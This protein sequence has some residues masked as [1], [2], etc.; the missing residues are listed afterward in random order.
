MLQCISI[1]FEEIIHGYIFI[2]TKYFI[3]AEGATGDKKADSSRMDTFLSV[4]ITSPSLISKLAAIQSEINQ[5][6][7][8][9]SRTIIHPS[10]FHLTLLTM[11]TGDNE[12]CVRN[13]VE[14]A[15]SVIYRHT[16]TH[17]LLC[18]F[19]QLNVVVSE[20]VK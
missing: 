9:A 5:S 1:L 19:V 12:A 10:V 14:L 3:L 16:G 20:C 13:A 17:G 4:R 8:S 6:H 11:H 2:F 18:E 7:A 15:Q